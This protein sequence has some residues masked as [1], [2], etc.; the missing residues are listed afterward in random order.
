MD[1]FGNIFVSGKVRTKKRFSPINFI[2]HINIHSERTLG[3]TA[4]NK[5][6]IIKGRSKSTYALSKNDPL[7]PLCHKA[8]H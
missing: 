8:S 4:I 1:A 5:S 7:S 6:Y 3:R 2:I